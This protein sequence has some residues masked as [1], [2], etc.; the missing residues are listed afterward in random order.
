MKEV[1][2]RH[3]YIVTHGDDLLI[4]AK[5]TIWHANRLENTSNYRLKAMLHTFLSIML[6]TKRIDYRQPLLKLA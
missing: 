5:D 3:N 6:G 2:Y 1:A 4:T